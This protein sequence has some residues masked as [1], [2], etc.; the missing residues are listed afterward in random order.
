MCHPD[1]GYEWKYAIRESPEE[2]LL[3]GEDT[4]K[5]EEEDFDIGWT[6]SRHGYQQGHPLQRIQGVANDLE[7]R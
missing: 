7:E 5:E 4:T 6:L 3:S 2:R 1:L